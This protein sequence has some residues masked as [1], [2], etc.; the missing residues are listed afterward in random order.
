VD[1]LE[2]LVAGRS[3]ALILATMLLLVIGLSGMVVGIEL[4]SVLD[5]AP[6][7]STGDSFSGL[8]FG[9][10]AAYGAITAIAGLGLALLRRWGW[11]LGVATIV[12][13]LLGLL[14]I[15][16]AV[17]PDSVLYLGILI[18]AATLAFLV[19]PGTRR[20]AVR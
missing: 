13:G 4:L 1:D 15:V 2:V 19:V 11:W 8:L 3:L 12:L 14:A 6:R 20:A 10:I 9:G 18:W 7:I 16:I 5:T 17:G